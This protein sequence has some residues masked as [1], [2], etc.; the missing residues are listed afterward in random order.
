M[1]DDSGG[2]AVDIGRFCTSVADGAGDGDDGEV[3][4]ADGAG[5]IEPG[6]GRFVLPIA[7]LC[8]VL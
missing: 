8:A 2:D 1:L 7:K 5:D 4:A 6:V 3:A